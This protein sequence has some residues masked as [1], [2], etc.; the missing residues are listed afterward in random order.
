MR[1]LLYHVTNVHNVCPKDNLL[2][3]EEATHGPKNI[4]PHGEYIGP[5]FYT[6]RHV[7][8]VLPA[9]SSEVEGFDSRIWIF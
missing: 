2:G 8:V 6:P 1:L 4:Q 5:T 9:S 3:L 7:L